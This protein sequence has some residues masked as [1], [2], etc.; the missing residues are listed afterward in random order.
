MVESHL[1]FDQHQ[2]DEQY[3]MVMLDIFVGEAF[4]LWALR[5]PNALAE[6]SVIGFAVGCVQGRHWRGTCYAD[7]H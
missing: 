5:Q 3:H 4:A 1:R 7:G 6:T 2:I